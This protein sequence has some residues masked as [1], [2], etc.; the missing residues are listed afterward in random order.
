MQPHR[1]HFVKP[2]GPFVIPSAGT[3]RFPSA[4]HSAAWRTTLHSS[5][6]WWNHFFSVLPRYPCAPLTPFTHL[7][8]SSCLILPL[9]CT[10][11][12]LG[13]HLTRFCSSSCWAGSRHSGGVERCICG[14]SLSLLTFLI[15]SVKSMT[16]IFPFCDSI[17]SWGL[18]VRGPQGPCA[19]WEI[20]TH[21]H[22][23]QAEGVNCGT[24]DVRRLVHI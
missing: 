11:C 15:A 20:L 4:L 14:D 9:D 5:L 2:A 6:A 13:S 17:V 7:S 8:S 18:M 1:L 22:T 16:S 3:P 21:S 23:H 24:L 12:E 10:P 19:L